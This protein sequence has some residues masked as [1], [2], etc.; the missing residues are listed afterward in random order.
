MENVNS[1]ENTIGSP[2]KAL[3]I[4]NLSYVSS[5]I[6]YCLLERVVH[7]VITKLHH[8]MEGHV[9]NQIVLLIT[10]SQ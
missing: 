9:K 3:K 8:R 5:D 2:H 10:S 7:V 1:V 4:V 6:I